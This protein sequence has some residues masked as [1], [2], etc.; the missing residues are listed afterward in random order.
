M[1]ARDLAERVPVVH[2]SDSALEAARLIASHR[3]SGIV[4]AND[5]DEPVA[6]V[7]GSQVLRIVVPKYVRD[8]PRLAHVYDEAGADE[9]CA[10]LSQRTVGDLLDDDEVTPAALPQVLPQDTLVEIASVMV[11]ERAPVVVVR[12][13]RGESPGVVTLA[14]VMAAILTAAG[15]A[16]ERVEHT[17]A[18]DLLD[19]DR[20]G[21]PDR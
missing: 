3:L 4:V 14:R 7:Q 5:E 1:L 11:N 16:D 8:D 2:R 18:R 10:K 6:V 15:S 20:D 19:L 21:E 13:E 17:L 12:D 9:L